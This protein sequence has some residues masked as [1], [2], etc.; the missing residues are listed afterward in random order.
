MMVVIFKEYNP[1]YC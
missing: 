1:F